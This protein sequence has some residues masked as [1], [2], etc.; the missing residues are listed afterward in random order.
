[1]R[2]T[3]ERTGGIAGMRL[4]H[5]LTSSALPD[6]DAAELKR[7][8]DASRFFD[9]AAHE[10]VTSAGSDRFSYA[11]AIDEGGR[12]HTV[13]VGEAEAPATLRPLIGWLTTAARRGDGTPAS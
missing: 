13:H 7:L 6:A 10:V 2:I 5:S 3:F 12:S 8:V 4:T 1:M 11:I 9:L